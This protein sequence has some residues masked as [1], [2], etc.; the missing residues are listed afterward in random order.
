M[1]I[2]GCRRHSGV[3]GCDDEFV[4]DGGE[5]AGDYGGVEVVGI[6]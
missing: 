4:E 3:R 1:F 5:E 2:S 6:C